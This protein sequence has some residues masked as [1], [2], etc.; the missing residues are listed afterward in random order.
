MLLNSVLTTKQKDYSGKTFADS[1]FIK[2]NGIEKKVK[3][4]VVFFRFVRHNDEKE[5][6]A[7]R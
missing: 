7:A 3:E 5:I 4:L 1:K 2:A 6:M